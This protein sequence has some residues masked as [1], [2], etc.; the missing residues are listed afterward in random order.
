MPQIALRDVRQT[1]EIIGECRELWADPREWRRHLLRRLAALTHCRLA[2]SVE[3]SGENGRLG[4]Q[5]LSGEDVGWNSES[6][7]RT[8]LTGITAVPL[9]FSPM[10]N[11]FA[12]RVADRRGFTV[13]QRDL[14]DSRRWRQSEMYDRFVR[15]TGIGEALM[16]AVRMDRTGSWDHWCICS[17]RSDRPPGAREMHLVALVHEQV[18][19]MLERRELAD[20]CDR[21]MA[22]LSAKRRQV[23]RLLLE[24]RSEKEIALAML[25]SP[26]TV[27][28]HI[29][30]VYEHFGVNSRAKLAAYFLRRRA[31]PAPTRSPPLSTPQAWLTAPRRPAAAAGPE[32]LG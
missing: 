22:E 7:R 3:V 6:E 5:L 12:S 32:K 1:L 19:R 28:E 2:F 13:L 8:L 23:L 17:D 27:H 16:S 10:W 11:A 4:E 29:E 9:S 31:A 24:G 15:P 20:W 26:P 30:H 25:R 14:I 18:V 21:S